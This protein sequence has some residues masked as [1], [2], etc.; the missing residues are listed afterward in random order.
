LNNAN[1]EQNDD[2]DDDLETNG[3]NTPEYIVEY[4]NEDNNDLGQK[5]EGKP[6]QEVNDEEINGNINNGEVVVDDN[7]DDDDNSETFYNEIT[8]KVEVKSPYHLDPSYRGTTNPKE[9]EKPRPADQTN[10]IYQP[11][12][13]LDQNS[14]LEQ[15]QPTSNDETSNESNKSDLDE[16][17]NDDLLNKNTHSNFTQPKNNEDG[18]PIPQPIGD[19]DP[20]TSKEEEEEI[21]KGKQVLDTEDTNN[22]INGNK[23]TSNRPA[24]KIDGYFGNSNGFS[25]NLLDE[26]KQL[27][28]N[29][30]LKGDSTTNKRKPFKTSLTRV[31]DA[32]DGVQNIRFNLNTVLLLVAILSGFIALA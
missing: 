28:Y 21:T 3:N 16:G 32:N 27:K 7:D 30:T 19:D 8:G 14:P 20:E 5:D 31:G 24:K 6:Y 17:T 9:L 23:S 12:P 13:T 22:L 26:Q 1:D 15:E 10:E 29:K 25:Q 2:D 18:H 4:G 11:D